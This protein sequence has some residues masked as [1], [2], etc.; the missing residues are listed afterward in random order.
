MGMNDDM[1]R[2]GNYLFNKTRRGLLTMLY[3]RPGEAFYVNQV[4]KDLGS[5][6]GAVQRELR[7]ATEAGLILREKKGNLVLYRANQESPIYN[8]L[9]SIIDKTSSGTS[10]PEDLAAQ[11]FRVNKQTLAEFCRKH[12]INKISLYG[13]VLQAEFHTNLPIKALVEFEPGYAPGYGIVDIENELTV[14]AEHKVAVKAPGEISRY[15]KTETTRQ[16]KVIYA[17]PRKQK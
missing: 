5:G 15:R 16:A 13:E 10:R 17:A 9:K 11:R 2:L 14:L 4:V 3:N 6:S 12:R 1:E 7:M 8:E